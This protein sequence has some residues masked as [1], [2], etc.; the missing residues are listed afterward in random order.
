MKV[1]AW[2]APSSARPSDPAGYQLGEHWNV[3]LHIYNVGS[4][5]IDECTLR[6]D[7]TGQHIDDEWHSWHN[8]TAY[9]SNWY[10]SEYKN[11]IEGGGPNGG[12][13][14][15]QLEDVER[16]YIQFTATVKWIDPDSGNERTAVGS[17]SM[18]V[19]SKTGVVLNKDYKD[20][21]NGEYFEEGEQIEWTLSLKNNSKEDL[22]NVTVRPSLPMPPSPPVR[23]KRSPFPSIPLPSMMRK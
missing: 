13:S 18:P 21:A 5:L 16:G 11:I 6:V 7:Y 22:T 17:C 23:R 9:G 4:V 2:F 10:E 20:P 1:D 14:I 19:I 3:W 15:I 12:G 8:V